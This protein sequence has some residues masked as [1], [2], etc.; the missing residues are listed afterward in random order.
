MTAGTAETIASGS[1]HETAPTQFVEADG[2]RFAYRRF[3]EPA[4]TPLVFFQ[5]FRGGIDHWDPL[6]TDGLAAARE[7]ILFDNAGVSG[8]SGETPS[9]I[10]EMADHGAAF[11]R[12]L[13]L[14][15]ADL[16]GFSIGGCVVQ[17]VTLR[18]PD[19]VRRQALVGTVPRGGEREG[20]HPD[21]PKVA[22]TP[23]PGLDDFLFL[24]FQPS[25]SSQEAGR[26][27]YARRTART[28]DIDPPSSL[29]TA[30]AQVTALADWFQPHGERYSDLHEI[31][32][33]TLVVNGTNDRML[34]TINSYTLV[35]HLPNAQLSIYPDSGHGALFQ[36]P[37]LFVDEVSRFLDAEP[38]FS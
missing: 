13:G 33:P 31:E 36:Y 4:G 9:T 29:Q 28:E 37:R 8:S 5:H 35:Q 12:A 16:L 1:N 21:V 11:I 6:V 32:Q 14:E 38:A 34:P 7:V 10:E 22:R 30:Q 2:I 26:Q 18:H 15:Q 17:A 23:V 3:G 25:E 20:A 27:F 19:L 24:F